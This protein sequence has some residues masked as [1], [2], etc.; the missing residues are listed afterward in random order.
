MESYLAGLP[1]DWVEDRET[2]FTVGAALSHQYRGGQV[3]FDKWCEWSKQS[4]KF[5]L[6]DSRAVWRSFKGRTGDPITFRSVIKAANEN[7]DPLGDLLG[8]GAAPDGSFFEPVSNWS[9]TPA[10]PR[11]WL[12]P[13]FIP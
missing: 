2:W 8:P 12:V 1:E 6:R 7:R 13:D 4:E 9:D 11:R 3:G 5:N 10:P